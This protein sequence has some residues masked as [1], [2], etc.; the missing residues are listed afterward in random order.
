MAGRIKVEPTSVEDPKFEA[1][2][3]KVISRES[4]P[5]GKLSTAKQVALGAANTSKRA[6]KGMPKKGVSKWWGD[7]AT[8][9]RK[10]AVK[11]LRKKTIG[12]RS[13]EQKNKTLGSAANP[14]K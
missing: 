11:Y 5:G 1:K 13:R 9:L 12:G 8:R 3:Q 14:G 7:A 10:S 4:K 6:D 2:R